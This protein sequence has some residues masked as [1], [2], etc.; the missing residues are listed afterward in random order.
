MQ[1]TKSVYG[2]VELFHW[3]AG[4]CCATGFVAALVG[5]AMVAFGTVQGI[6]VGNP[7]DPD[8]VQTIDAGLN[9]GIPAAMIA[10]AA[11]VVSAVVGGVECW[12]GVDAP[13]ASAKDGWGE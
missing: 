11:A 2:A 10:A 13:V 7:A 3:A 4:L 1:A 5:A 12:L 9:L 6:L 8:F